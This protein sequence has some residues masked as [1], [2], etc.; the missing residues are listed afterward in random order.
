VP[1]VTGRPSYHP[2][3]LLKIY[4]YGYINQ[5][6]SS[7][8]LE[9]EAGRN[10]EMMWLTERLAPDFKTIAD[11]RK[12]NGPAIRAACRQFIALCRKV[13]PSL[14]EWRNVRHGRSGAINTSASAAAHRGGALRHGAG[15]HKVFQ[16]VSAQTVGGDGRKTNSF[17]MIGESAKSHSFGNPTIKSVYWRSQERQLF[18]QTDVPNCDTFCKPNM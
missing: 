5:I 4:V 16:I 13:R 8:K 6:A 17:Q 11:F 7:R 2:G 10:V 18:L 3:L 15:E 14:A 9:R 1:E 12:D